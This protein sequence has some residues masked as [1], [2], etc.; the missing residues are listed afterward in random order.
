MKLAGNASDA[1]RRAETA[2]NNARRTDP[3][4]KN[5]STKT[6]QATYDAARQRELEQT[7]QNEQAKG[8]F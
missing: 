6:L 5:D 1:R 4:G 8:F 3:Q 2:L 7:G